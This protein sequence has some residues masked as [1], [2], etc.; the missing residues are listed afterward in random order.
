MAR[1]QLNRCQCECRFECAATPQMMDSA[2]QVLFQELGECRAGS[3]RAERRLSWRRDGSITVPKM[4]RSKSMYG[5]RKI[6]VVDTNPFMRKV[7]ALWCD[8][9]GFATT[10]ASDGSE[11]LTFALATSFCLIITNYQM[12]KLNGL[13][14]LQP[15]SL[16]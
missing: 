7:I 2:T 4:V 1:I 9:A 13:D 5:M 16:F 14:F 8:K 15:A 3:T 12:P 11:A 6:L 10:L